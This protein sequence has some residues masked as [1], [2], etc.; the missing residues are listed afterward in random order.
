M[1]GAQGHTLNAA[2]HPL[3]SLG[4]TLIF[5]GRQA[6]EAGAP[7]GMARAAHAEY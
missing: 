7:G 6:L 4:S 5:G 2:P 1:E 3:P